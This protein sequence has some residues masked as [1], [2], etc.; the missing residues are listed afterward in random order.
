MSPRSPVGSNAVSVAMVRAA[1]QSATT[2][3][4]HRRQLPCVAV[5]RCRTIYY[6]DSTLSRA[7]HSDATAAAGCTGR[8][9]AGVRQRAWM[10]VSE[11][12]AVHRW[13]DQRAIVRRVHCGH[14][15]KRRPLGPGGNPISVKNNEVGKCA[16]GKH[17]VGR[18]RAQRLNAVGG[19]KMGSN[20]RRADCG[21]ARGRVRRRLSYRPD[22][23]RQ[24]ERTRECSRPCKIIFAA[25]R[26]VLDEA[27]VHFSDRANDPRL[28]RNA[29][30]SSR[31]A[32]CWH[33]APAR[34]VTWLR[35]RRRR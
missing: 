20:L 3:A 4:S 32:K 35:P 21:A 24:G 2:D 23:K 12:Q 25:I 22:V 28:S 26:S 16:P 27:R 11:R 5:G 6:H 14:R 17:N 8:R 31:D 15:R 7:H 1:P 19:D 9:Q 29:S 30:R 33:D 34:P 18:K 10:R 13:I